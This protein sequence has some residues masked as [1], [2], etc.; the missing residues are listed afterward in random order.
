MRNVELVVEKKVPERKLTIKTKVNHRLDFAISGKL[1]M[2][3][4]EDIATIT[5]GLSVSNAA[6]KDRKI[7]YGWQLDLNV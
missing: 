1:P 7:S 4:F 5:K 3:G 2:W 6:G